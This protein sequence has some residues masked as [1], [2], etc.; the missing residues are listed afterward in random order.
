MLIWAAMPS[1]IPQLRGPIGQQDRFEL[2]DPTILA[3]RLVAVSE[4]VQELH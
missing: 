2:A 3:L 4:L 1:S